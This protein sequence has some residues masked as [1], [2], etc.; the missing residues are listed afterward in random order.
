MIALFKHEGAYQPKEYTFT[1]YMI[2]KSY[3]HAANFPDDPKKIISLWIVHLAS[4]A[5][6][7]QQKQFIADLKSMNDPWKIE[8]SLREYYFLR[9][10]KKTVFGNHVNIF[11]SVLHCISDP[12]VKAK[13]L[14][15]NYEPKKI[16]LEH[17]E[18]AWFNVSQTNLRDVLK[19][20]NLE[21]E[22]KEKAV[23]A[24]VM[25]TYQWCLPVTK[26]ISEAHYANLMM[27]YR[28]DIETH[29]EEML[30]GYEEQLNPKQNTVGDS[31]VMPQKAVASNPVMPQLLIR[32]Y[33][34]P[35]FQHWLTQLVLWTVAITALLVVAAFMVKATMLPLAVA[36][37]VAG[38]SDFASKAIFGTALTVGLVTSAV[39]IHSRFFVPSL[40][41]SSNNSGGDHTYEL[42][43]KV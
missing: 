3:L 37:V 5:E 17:L 30:K 36:K 25:L 41:P 15:E 35:L 28:G 11:Y 24:A 19:D 13:D 34:N 27:V 26:A 1:D 38:L 16:A 33:Q 39:L 23:H 43:N 29:Y 12:R 18:L 32:L 14:A 7:E 4:L 31:L 40:L 22:E 42:H 21:K 20:F 6:T 8:V 9:N 2:Y 10:D